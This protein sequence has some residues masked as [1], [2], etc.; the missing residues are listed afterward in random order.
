[1]NAASKLA[2]AAETFLRF[3][4]EDDFVAWPTEG[5]GEHEGAAALLA[6]DATLLSGDA[7]LLE[8]S[9]ISL[10]YRALSVAALSSQV[11]RSS[12]VNALKFSD[13]N[14]PTSPNGTF[15]FAARNSFR[16]ALQYNINADMFCFGAF[17]SRFFL[18]LSPPSDN[19]D[20][21]ASSGAFFCMVKFIKTN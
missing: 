3:F 14:L 7:T 8:Y 9:A 1:M 18:V 10:W 15:G 2:E 16:A 6:G 4:A 20:G 13:S 17:G 21:G 12:A 19:L 11:A 5:L